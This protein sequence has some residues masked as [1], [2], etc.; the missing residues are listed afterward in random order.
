MSQKQSWIRLPQIVS[1]RLLICM[2]NKNIFYTVDCTFHRVKFEIEDKRDSINDFAQD[3]TSIKK[4][5][6]IVYYAK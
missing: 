3:N 6:E 4:Y 2:V 5:L 1:G